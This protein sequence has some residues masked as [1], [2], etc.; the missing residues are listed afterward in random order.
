[1]RLR[2]VVRALMLACLG[3]GVLALP[4]R[5]ANLGDLD[6]SSYIDPADVQLL[7][8]VYG[9]SA[10]SL[11]YD[12]GADLNSDQMIDYRDLAVLASGM[13]QIADYVPPGTPFLTVDQVPD[14]M[15][16]LL[17]VPTSGFVVNYTIANPPGAPLIDLSTM[18]ILT[19]RPAG[20][21]PAGTN[22]APLF[23]RGPSLG[24]WF[25]DAAHAFPPLNASFL[26]QVLNRRGETLELPYAVAVRNWGIPIPI[27]A[28]QKV[29]L[30][31]GQDRDGAGGND[32]DE[33]LR[34]F[35]LGSTASPS[36]SAAVRV[37][38]IERSL[39]RVRAFYG[40]DADGSPGPDPVTVAF[41]STSAAGATR[42]CVGGEDPSG[43]VTFGLTPFD[44]NNTQTG[45]DTCAIS[46]TYGVFPREF[47]FFAGNA[48][49]QAVFNPLRSA[50]GGVPVGEHALDPVVL[51]P[52]FDPATAPPDQ[53][54]RWSLIDAAESTFA[55]FVATIAAHESGHTLG[56]TAA[57]AAPGGLWGGSSGGYAYHNVATSGGSPSQN[58]LMNSGSAFTYERI[59]GAAGTALPAIRPLNAAYLRNR[60]MLKSNISALLPA[61]ALTSV[62][63]NPAVY[64]GGTVTITLHGSSFYG[65]PTVL[66]KRTGVTPKQVQGITLIDPNTVQGTVNQFQAGTGTYDVELTNPDDQ[67]V[68]LTNGLTLQ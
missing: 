37:E 12:G 65:V 10:G 54:A 33:D 61:P 41:S 42:I 52:G 56:L 34:A 40:Q 59:V 47:L 30:D 7:W 15:N 3:M 67:A 1:M 39:A 36:L 57:G 28:S 9:S 11:A 62:T 8:T 19:D 43:G 49:F 29:F 16:N 4:S 26:F 55:Q 53:A 50:A 60:L 17:V 35:G 51:A 64:A 23:Q 68:L 44:K 2:A 38:V 66:L 58:F 24:S 21:L 48:N 32:F 31:F 46:P 20:P 6:G 18:Y 5:A 13:G 25:V 27:G 22:L 45:T 63:P 14:D